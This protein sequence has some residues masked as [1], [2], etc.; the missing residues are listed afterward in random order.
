MQQKKY[1]TILLSLAFVDRRQAAGWRL[2]HL[3]MFPGAGRSSPVAAVASKGG[4]SHHTHGHGHKH[5][6][7]E[8]KRELV[9]SQS[10][11]SVLTGVHVSTPS[12]AGGG[13]STSR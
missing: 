11:Q 8:G 3:A 12:F 2:H 1:C 7:R 5:E 6:K 13:R 9:R 4:K 10:N